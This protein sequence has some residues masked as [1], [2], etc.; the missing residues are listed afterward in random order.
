MVRIV[1]PEPEPLRSDNEPLTVEELK[2]AWNGATLSNGSKQGV[3]LAVLEAH[4]GRPMMPQEVIDFMTARTEWHGL[5]TESGRYF[6]RKGS[7]LE[8][9][10]DGTW[11]RAA[12]SDEALILAR[13]A[14]RKRIEIDRRSGVVRVDPAA[15]AARK[16]AAEQRREANADE[17]ASL[18]RA[19]LVG[20]PT[21]K[22]RAVV[23]LDVGQRTI[24][25][26]VDDQF[27][28][29]RRRVAEYDILGAENIRPLLQSLGIAEEG[30][31]LAELS[32]PQKTITIDDR[33]KKLKI[34]TELLVKSSCGI[35]RPFGDPKKLSGYLAAG[36]LT[37]VCR[38]L[39]ADIKSLYAMY[40]YGRVH[41]ALRLVYGAVD[42]YIPVPWVYWDERRL[43]HLLD[44]AFFALRPIQVVFGKAPVW[45][46]PWATVC[47]ARIVRDLAARKMWL[48]DE[49]GKHIPEV[50]VQRARLISE[51]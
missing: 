48:F 40:E 29:L 18:T 11:N 34:T 44:A 14:V 50:D 8:V 7:S 17:Y 38:R 35:S 26:F 6:S 46:D 9:G 23:L 31:R 30:K 20:F 43:Y 5:H 32:P 10:A 49:D 15:L 51:L 16:K 19:L 37:K 21:K 27:D 39:E 1:Q 25:T 2:E 45:N 42:T 33:G 22:P 41:G 24:Q 4:G 28:E 3:I 13:Q 12:D 47:N 36:D